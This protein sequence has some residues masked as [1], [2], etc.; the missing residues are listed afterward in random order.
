MLRKKIDEKLDLTEIYSDVTPSEKLEKVKEINKNKNCIMVGDGINDSPALKTATI[1]ISVNGGSDISQDSADIILLNDN[2]NNIYELF[3]IG[4]KTMRVIKQNLFW[5]LFYNICMIPLA[6]G[7]LTISIN[8][9]ISSLAM[10]FS[11]LTVVLNS[12]RLLK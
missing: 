9:M 3:N 1:G 7:L 8:P 2:M 5:A 6:T 4:H 12:L 11:S 10:T